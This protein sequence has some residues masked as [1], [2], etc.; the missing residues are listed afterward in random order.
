MGLALLTLIAFISI[1][2]IILFS[3]VIFA[4]KVAKAFITLLTDGLF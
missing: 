1:P 3:V 4:W 2:L